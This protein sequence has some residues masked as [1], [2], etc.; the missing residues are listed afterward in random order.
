M[1]DVHQL[2]Q[3]LEMKASIIYF[4]GRKNQNK[5]C[6]LNLK[7]FDVQ[8]NDNKEGKP[9]LVKS[10][11]FTTKYSMGQTVYQKLHEDMCRV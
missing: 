9:Q 4:T 8:K 2:L 3:E 6:N 11:I 1:V 7:N 5:Y 10:V